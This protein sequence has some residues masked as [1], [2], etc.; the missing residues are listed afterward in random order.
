MIDLWLIAG[1]G[2]LGSFGH[3]VS[4]CG[5]LA[6]AFAVTGRPDR[7]AQNPDDSPKPS[8]EHNPDHWRKHLIFHILLNLGRI[9]SYALVGAGI[10]LLGSV[11]IAGGQFAGVGSGLRRG[12]SLVTGSLLIWFGLCQVMPGGLP[13][14][15]LIHPLFQGNWH[16]RLSRA[17]MQVSL[18]SQWFMPLLLGL[19]WGM[20]P[21]GFLYA[22]QIKAAETGDILAGTATMLAFGAGTLPTMV[23][24][25][26]STGLVS[27]DRRSQL[28]QMGGWLTIAIGLLTLTR[29]GDMMV[30]YTGYGAV[31][32]LMLALI[33]RPCRRI[34]P[35]LL[36]Y[37]R[38]LGVGS[39]VFA[40]VHVIHTLEHS[41]SWNLEA[42]QFLIPK[43]QW[44]IWLGLMALLLLFPL[45]LTSNDT[46]QK[47]LGNQWRRLHL[48]AVPGLMLAGGHVLLTG[49]R[50]LGSFQF[51]RVNGLWAGILVVLV[52]GVLLLRCAWFWSLLSLGNYYGSSSGSSE[53]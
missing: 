11:L 10:G 9:L 29:T 4:M 42:M 47:R 7:P 17:M 34:W 41:W 40:A 28:F 46:M 43:A 1:L 33:A 5:P 50:Y 3:C 13:R 18:R 44:G 14:L 35:G 12:L 15:P 36:K 52:L 19:L 16:D 20:I 26:L 24:V 21:C 2:F 30:D 22:A 38:L 51:T 27:A 8:P 6:I 53:V 39:F 32:C 23:G 48:L 25:G 31:L 49:S 45:A 37:R